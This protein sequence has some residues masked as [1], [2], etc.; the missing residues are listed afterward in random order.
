MCSLVHDDRRLFANHLLDYLARLDRRKRLGL[1]NVP[2]CRVRVDGA[3]MVGRVLDA[4]LPA[5]PL[6]LHQLLLLALVRQNNQACRVS[7]GLA[8]LR[9]F[10]HGC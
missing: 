2:I 7:E 10:L 3:L 4:V 5:S 1:V 9:I 8:G 6:V